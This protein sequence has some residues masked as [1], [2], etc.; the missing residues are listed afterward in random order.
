MAK[1]TVTIVD[2]ETGK[3]NTFT[4]L[5]M[6]LFNG[7]T[8]KEHPDGKGSDIGSH[9][10]VNGGG[11]FLGPMLMNFP[12]FVG[13]YVANMMKNVGEHEGMGRTYG[14]F[15]LQE[16]RRELKEHEEKLIRETS[17]EDIGKVLRKAAETFSGILSDEAVR[18][19]MDDDK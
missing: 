19:M 9:V 4:G 16:V 10:V 13:R 18:K 2:E 12:K 5:D 3:M 14:S 15:M 7:I 11:K 1:Y 17:G 8:A 6:V